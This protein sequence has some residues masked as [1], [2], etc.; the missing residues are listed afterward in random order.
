MV[1]QQQAQQVQGGQAV[2]CHD[3]VV[4]LGVGLR[5]KRWVGGRELQIARTGGVDEGM[6]PTP[7]AS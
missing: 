6:R 7:S 2:R 5:L 3:E 1:A 4:H